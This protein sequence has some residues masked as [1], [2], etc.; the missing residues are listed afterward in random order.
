MQKTYPREEVNIAYHPTGYRIDK[1]AS[2]MNFYTRWQIDEEERWREFEP[3]DFDALP[4]FGWIK[5]K[6]FNWNEKK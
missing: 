2:P 4:R 5:S 1:T 6:G 3:V